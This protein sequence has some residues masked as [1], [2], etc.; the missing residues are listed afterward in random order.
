MHTTKRKILLQAVSFAVG[1][2]LMTACRKGPTRVDAGTVA[3]DPNVEVSG[4]LKLDRAALEER[5]EGA[6]FEIDG[7]GHSHVVPLLPGALALLH[8]NRVVI[9]RSGPATTDAHSHWIRVTM[10]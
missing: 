10:A 7:D 9:V 6:L 2:A 5:G 8:A 4:V 3:D 1:A